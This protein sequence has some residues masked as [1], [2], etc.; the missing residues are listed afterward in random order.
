M[1]E[2]LIAYYT[3]AARYVCVPRSNR[4]ACYL[5]RRRK[6]NLVEKKLLR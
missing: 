1:C 4:R 2:N 5:S 3:N 6:Q